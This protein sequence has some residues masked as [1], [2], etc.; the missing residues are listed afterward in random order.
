MVIKMNELESK[1]F[2]LIVKAENRLKEHEKALNHERLNDDY[3]GNKF[4]S[5]STISAQY[6]VTE[7]K[8]YLK[9]LNDVKKEL[10]L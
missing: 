8:A 7:S 4:P 5:S 3:S 1:L 6:K 10:N 2:A 9:A